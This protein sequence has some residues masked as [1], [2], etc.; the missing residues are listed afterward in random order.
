VKNKSKKQS[1][2]SLQ[3]RFIIIFIHITC[4][5][6]PPCFLHSLL[7]K[8][9]KVCT[10]VV[11][12]L[13]VAQ[14]LT[15]SCAA[16]M[17]S[18]EHA[19]FLEEMRASHPVREASRPELNLSNELM[20]RAGLLFRA[21]DK[22]GD[23]FVGIRDIRRSYDN[24]ADHLP[25]VSRAD[26]SSFIEAADSDND[27]LL[28]H[29]ELLHALSAGMQ[30][31]NQESFL[32][33]SATPKKAAAGAAGAAGAGGNDGCVMCQ[34]ILERCETNVKQSG[35]IPGMTAQPAADG[36]YLEVESKTGAE[37][38]AADPFDVAGAG[39][40]ASTRQATR[41]ARLL[42]RQKFNEIYRVVDITL[43][44]VCEQGMPSPFYGYC[45]NIY[46]A[47]SDVVDGLRYQYR[48]SDICFRIGM[49]AKGS[50]ITQGIHSRYNAG[51]A[52][53]AK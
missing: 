25:G 13:L 20:D 44:D 22:D 35:V 31:D 19:A 42:E 10:L 48:P 27:G 14:A 2:L 40:I 53:G 39:I 45:K 26:F 1:V 9:M 18:S 34:Y 21:L 33:T 7:F 36:V 51:N 16:E 37:A 5:L 46:S 15:I 12:A 41:Y 29:D 11:V 4:T 23:Q 38:E 30:N 24:L 43:D 8:T 50:Y 52:A 28:S 3:V 49:C 32:E 47:Q 17:T 6:F